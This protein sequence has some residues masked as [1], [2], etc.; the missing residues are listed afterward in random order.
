M[1]FETY[2]KNESKSESTIKNYLLDVDN[3]KKWFST[4]FGKEVTKLFRENILDY[5]SYLQNV[6]GVSSVTINRHLNSLKKFNQYLIDKEVQDDIV[7]RSNDRLKIQADY[8]SPTK[9]S[10]REVGSFMQDVLENESKRNYTIVVV[11][12][13]TGMRISEALGSKVD[14]FNLVAREWVIPQGKGNK[15]RVVPINDKVANVLRMYIKEREKYSYADKSK[16]LFISRQGKKLNRTTVNKMFKKYS[17]KVTPHQLRHFFVTDA[18]KKGLTTEEVAFI[19][20]HSSIQTTMRYSHPDQNELR[21][22][23]ELL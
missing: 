10:E 2:L 17:D 15:R 6:K 20:G 18:R 16:Y 19:A 12:R 21:G 5:R 7:I 14:D 9:V 8:L 1:E 23:M 3:Y 22:K 13:Y 11:L 4:S